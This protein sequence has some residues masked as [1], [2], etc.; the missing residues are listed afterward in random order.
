M[1]LSQVLGEVPKWG[2]WEIHAQEEKAHSSVFDSSPLY[3][4]PSFSTAVYSTYPTMA[5]AGAGAKGC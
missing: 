3:P 2:R 4:F 5:S 1:H